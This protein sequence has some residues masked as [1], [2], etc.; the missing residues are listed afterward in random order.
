MLIA[1]LLAASHLTFHGGKLLTDPRYVDVFWGSYW[2]TQQG[3]ADA[4]WLDGFV[5]AV[6]TSQGLLSQVVE[7]SAPGQPL[8]AGA[9]ESSHLIT[10]VD[11]GTSIAETTVQRYVQSQLDQGLLPAYDASRVYVIFLPPGVH[12]PAGVQIGGYHGVSGTTATPFNSVVSTFDPAQNQGRTEAGITLSHEMAE[13]ITDQDLGWFDD[14]LGARG[15]V[16]DLCEGTQATIAG[17]SVQQEWSNELASCAGPR[18]LTQPQGGG[19]P[20]GSHR[21]GD[22]CAPDTVPGCS[23][24][25][26]GGL[27]V[28]GLAVM[29]LARRSRRLA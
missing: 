26:A 2:T 4:A 16:G 12:D 6:G 17:Y 14:A 24:S 25:G 19:C 22:F 1:I 7:Y 27:A 21:D 15:E 5:A 11:L 8:H 3:Q 18:E 29:A 28:L 9:F 13:A 20:A 23:S 10:A